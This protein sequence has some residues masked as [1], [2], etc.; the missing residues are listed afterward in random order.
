MTSI[1]AALRKAAGIAIGAARPLAYPNAPERPCHLHRLAVSHTGDV[2]PCCL[3]YSSA[4]H[5]IGNIRDVDLAQKI[6][7][8]DRRCSCS[9]AK[10]RA[11]RPGDPV[12]DDRFLNLEL[13]LQCQAE[14]AMCCVDAPGWSGT[15][16][17]YPQLTALIR[18]QD[19]E[20]IVMQGGEVLVQ[21][22]SMDWIRSV[23]EEFPQ[24]KLH[25]VTNGCA[26]ASLAP[27]V[28]RLFQR[29]VISFVGIQ[30]ETYRAVMGL[31]VTRTLS[32]VQAL[33]AEQTTEVTMKFLATP[34]NVHEAALFLRTALEM[35]PALILF[36]DSGFHQYVRLKT[37]DGFWEK[38]ASR[39]G[40]A[41]QQQLC[42]SSAAL[43]VAGIRV[44]VEP[45]AGK[46]LGVDS[47]FLHEKNLTDV[48]ATLW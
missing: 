6:E 11:K 25:L 39:A 18:E 35:K 30:P 41:F 24:K 17:L 36:S 5:R 16:D 13:S 22:R 15:Y 10:L 2:F 46:V 4:Y 47:A 48:V 37:R 1:M 27:E 3:V 34:L 45:S 42:A 9:G 12:G 8:Y 40:T 21:K 38:I 7:K 33:I 32:F 26:P 23:R 28:A 43:K 29:V 44:H 19:P 20:G 14:C 31:D